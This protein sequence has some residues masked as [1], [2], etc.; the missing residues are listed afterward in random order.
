MSDS[1]AKCPF[2]E[3]D[4]FRAEPGGAIVWRG[5]FASREAAETRINELLVS[6]PAEYFTHSQSTGNKVFFKPNGH[7]G[8]NGN[9]G[10]R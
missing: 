1:E 5:S 2:D 9:N 3:V 7:N 8:H 10:A 6:D 4:I